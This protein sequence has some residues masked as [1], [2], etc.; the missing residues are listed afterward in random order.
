MTII[1]IFALGYII[2]RLAQARQYSKMALPASA[3]VVELPEPEIVTAAP[4]IVE[5]STVKPTKPAQ[6]PQET[7]EQV[8][9]VKVEQ[10]PTTDKEAARAAREARRAAKLE[11]ER[12]QAQ[13]DL[14]HFETMREGYM[15]LYDTLESELTDTTITDRRRAQLQRQILILE[16]KLYQVDKKRN[17][18]YFTIHNAA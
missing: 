8:E 7:A 16:E 6:E 4:V 17:K 3:P 13:L 1:V 12:Q 2:G 5:V 18:A 9:P 10:T 15:A 11:Y 14:E